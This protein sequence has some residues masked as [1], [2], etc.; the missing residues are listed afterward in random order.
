MINFLKPRECKSNCMVADATLYTMYVHS[1]RCDRYALAQEHMS[2]SNIRMLMC[3]KCMLVW[4]PYT[5]HSKVWQIFVQYY[6]LHGIKRFPCPLSFQVIIKV[7]PNMAIFSLFSHC[8]QSHNFTTLSMLQEFPSR[9]IL[10]E[11]YLYI[12]TCTLDLYI[13]G[14]D[15]LKIWSWNCI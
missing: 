15:D 10:L 13:F 8:K 5:T 7:I 14:D 6:L 2:L 12:I 4:I 11:R 1:L 9:I 3:M